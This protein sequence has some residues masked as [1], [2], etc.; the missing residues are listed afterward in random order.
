MRALH[1][2][3][4]ENIE[5]L[6]INDPQSC[7]TMVCFG[8]PHNRPIRQ[9]GASGRCEGEVFRRGNSLKQAVQD[10]QRLA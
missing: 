10:S 7:R 1:V 8:R 6:T 3:F 5:R 2:V 9:W 4:V